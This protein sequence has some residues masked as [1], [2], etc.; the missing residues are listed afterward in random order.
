MLR[1]ASSGILSGRAKLITR[2]LMLRCIFVGSPN[3]FTALMVHWLS[4]H[5]DLCGA[6]WTSSAHW[7][8]SIAGRLRFASKR[9]RRFGLLKTVDEALYYALS[10]TVLRINGEDVQ[11]R[12]VQLYASE[13]GAPTWQGAAIDT[14]DINSPQ[15][16]AFV[17]QRSPDLI[18]SLCINE[19]FGRQLRETPRLGSFLWHEGLI[20]EYKGLYSPFWAVHN[21]E[22]HMLGYTVLR[23]N[24]HYDAGDVYLQGK[25]R[26]IDPRRDS[27]VFIGHKAI[28]DSLP[29]VGKL[30]ED[31]ETGTADP[32]PINNRAA[33]TYTYPGF[34]DWIRLRRRVART[35]CNVLPEPRLKDL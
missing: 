31:L 30:F 14:G 28:L 25:V 19:F 1:I 26:N 23:M 27:S 22:P 18:M 35:H 29:A 10:K 20:P 34:S 8:G 6:V 32:I 15:V 12:L 21:G 13:Y 33:S 11:N 24:G 3:R 7:P 5:T 9:L 2:Q 17:R 4:K 16:L